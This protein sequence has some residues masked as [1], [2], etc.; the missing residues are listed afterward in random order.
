MNQKRRDCKCNFYYFMVLCEFKKSNTKKD[1]KLGILIINIGIF[2]HIEF[3]HR[4]HHSFKVMLRGKS[5]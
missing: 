5:M 2:P 1:Y 4:E 3:N